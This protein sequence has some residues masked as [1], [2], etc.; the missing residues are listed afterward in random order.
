VA[1]APVAAPA[2][3]SHPHKPKDPK[4]NSIA[5]LFMIASSSSLESSLIGRFD[6]KSINDLMFEQWPY[7]RES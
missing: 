3:N 5:T 1:N 4:S 2:M 7:Q 6:F